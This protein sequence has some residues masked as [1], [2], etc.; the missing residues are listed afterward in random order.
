[1][2]EQSASDPAW[3]PGPEPEDWL[4]D[5][6]DDCDH[7]TVQSA[8]PISISQAKCVSGNGH[9]R[10]RQPSCAQL[11]RTAAPTPLPGTAS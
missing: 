7:D 3:V 1:M 10:D 6:R 4:A 11:R 2:S 5:R 9:T 8:P